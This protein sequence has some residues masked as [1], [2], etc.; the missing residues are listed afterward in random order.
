MMKELLMFII[1]G[2]MKNC[3]KN[4]KDYKLGGLTEFARRGLQVDLGFMVMASKA[5][6]LW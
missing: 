4:Y 2:I 5:V 1:G 6:T 3:K